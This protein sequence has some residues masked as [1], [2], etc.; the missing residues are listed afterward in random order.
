MLTV[1]PIILCGGQGTRLWPLSRQSYPKQFLSLQGK[2]KDS[3]LQQTYKRISE[4]ERLDDPIIICNE[5]HR[6]LVAEQM[7][8]IGVKPKAIILENEGRNTAPAITLGAIKALEIYKEDT[9]LLVL[10]ADHIIEKVD[11]FLEVL[12]KG[13]DCAEDNKL[14]TFGIIPKYPETGY[15]YI[16]SESVFKKGVINTSKIKQFI[17]KPNKELAKKL[18]QSNKFTWNSGMFIFKTSLILKEIEN[19][20]PMVLKQCKKA[21]NQNIKDLD[22]TRINSNEFSKTPNIPI[23]IAVMEKTNLGL[24]ISLDAGWSDIGSWKSLW[25]KEKKDVSGNFIKG[26]VIDLDSKD[27]YIRSENRLLVTLGLKDLIVVE[28]QDAILVANKANSEKIKSI[29]NQLKLKGY[30][31]GLIHKKIFRPWGNYISLVQD[32]RWQVKRIEVSPGATLSLQMH[33]H[34]AEHWTVVEGTAKV[35]INEKVFILSENQSTFIPLGAKHRLSNPGKINLT[36]IEV[37]SG[38]YLG[39]DDIIR[40]EDQYGRKPHN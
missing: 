38:D 2:N 27:C 37:Q 11:I 1:V 24:V 35:E 39:E 36:L 20:S 23:D 26:K 21:M 17:E 28:T 9:L 33:H 10:S 32:K 15:G 29:V 25:E 18:I 6:F 19:H 14:V 7:R 13:I 16:E 8:C 3:L 34:R 12:K 4:L 22:F 5:E 30:E 40:F 31:E